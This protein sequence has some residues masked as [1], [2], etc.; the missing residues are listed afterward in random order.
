MR[1]GLLNDVRVLDKEAWPLMVE[2]YV[3]LAYDK[4]LCVPHKICRSHCY[5]RS[6]R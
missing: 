3:A 5:G 4:V 2:R 1:Y 6:C